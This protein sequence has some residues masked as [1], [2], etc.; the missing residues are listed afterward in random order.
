MQIHGSKGCGFYE[1]GKVM[2]IEHLLHAQN[3]LANFVTEFKADTELTH[4][5]RYLIAEKLAE[6]SKG[7]VELAKY[8]EK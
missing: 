4:I 2:N 1:R 6:V 5:D 3:A 8:L 7:I